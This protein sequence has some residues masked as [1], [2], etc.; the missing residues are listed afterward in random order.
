MTQDGGANNLE[1]KNQM[2]LDDLRITQFAR[3]DSTNYAPPT[4]AL[5]ITVDAPPTVDPDWS[6]V[7]VRS[8]F[9]TNAN[10]IAAGAPNGGVPHAQHS[11]SQIL[12]TGQKYGAGA[13]RHD[14]DIAYLNYYNSAPPL[15][16]SGTWTIE[17]WFRLENFGASGG[18]NSDMRTIWS[19]SYGSGSGDYSFGYRYSKTIMFITDP[20]RTPSSSFGEMVQPFL[21]YTRIIYLSISLMIIIMLL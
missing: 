3:Y 4:A 5:S 20:R 14:S 16:P 19:Q 17:F 10:N 13:L 11:A 15:D 21:S 8:T 12:T 2:Y 9:D 18:I 1:L 6:N 7:I